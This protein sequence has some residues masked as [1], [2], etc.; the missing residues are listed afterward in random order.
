[1]HSF[2]QSNFFHY[3]EYKQLK[4]YLLTSKHEILRSGSTVHLYE[5]LVIQLHTVTAIG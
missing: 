5:S 3:C 2:L 4:H 1:M